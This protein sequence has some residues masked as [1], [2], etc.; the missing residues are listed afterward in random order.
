[1]RR[2]L[3]RP[4][5]LYPTLL[6]IGALIAT[7]GILGYSK[8]TREDPLADLPDLPSPSPSELGVTTMMGQVSAF[9]ESGLTEDGP[10]WKPVGAS[11]C[12]GTG[13]YAEITSGTSVEVQDEM[14]VKLASGSLQAGQREGELCVWR[15]SLQVPDRSEY[16]V[17]VPGKAAV[18][19][20]RAM[21]ES[22]EI[23]L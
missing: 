6:L 17:K 13:Q 3:K 8:L 22:V 15:F 5:I 20:V 16:K 11:G 10:R 21:R 7:V 19:L 2:L 1:M 14:G 23:D 12:T 9:L 18:S 4:L